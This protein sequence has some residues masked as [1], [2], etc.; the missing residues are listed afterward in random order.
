M[1]D[2]K[3]NLVPNNVVSLADARCQS[4]GCKAKAKRASFCDEHFEW[5]KAGLITKEGKPASDFDKK[6]QHFL[7]AKKKAA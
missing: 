7:S 6:Y 3:P 2:K 4:E 5:F 1:A